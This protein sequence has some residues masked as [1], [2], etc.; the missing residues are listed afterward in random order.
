MIRLSIILISLLTACSMLAQSAEVRGRVMCGKQPVPFAQVGLMRDGSGALADSSGYFAFESHSTYDDTLLVMSIGFETLRR[1]IKLG[2]KKIDLGIVELVEIDL[3]AGEIVVSGSLHAVNRLESIV[4]VEVYSRG[5]LNKNPVC[6]VFES[7]QQMNGVRPQINCNICS[8]GDIHINGMEGPYTM[9]LIDGMPIVSSLATVYGFSG[10]PAS[11]IERVEVVK[12]PAGALYG[13]EAMGGLI[14]IIT[15]NT[16]DR[17]Q[18]ALDLMSTSWLEHNLDASANYRVGKKMSMLSSLN[19]FHFDERIDQNNDRFTD[20]PT[21]KRIS[22]FQKI[23][24]SRPSDKLFSIAGRYL[25]EDRFGGE[26]HWQRMH[27]GGRDVYG[28]S[29]YTSRSEIISQYELPVR[30]KMVFSLS[31]NDHRQN[32]VYGETSFIARQSIAFGQLTHEKMVGQHHF[33]SGLV[34]RYTYYDDNTAATAMEL[35]PESGY[36]PHQWLHGIFIQDEYTWNESH[37]T[38]GGLRLEY[39]PL[40]GEI[41]TPRFG[42]RWQLNAKQLLRLNAGKGFRVVNIFTEDHAALTGARELVIVN[43]LRPETSWNVNMN[44]H[45]QLIAHSQRRLSLDATVYYTRF[46]NRIVADYETNAN[47]IIYNNISG[48]AEGLGSSVTLEGNIGSVFSGMFGATFM[49]NRIIDNGTMRR[50]LLTERFSAV[51]SLSFSFRKIPLS[52]D[53]TGNMYSPMALP[54]AGSLDP[55]PS[56]SPWWSIQNIQLK[57]KSHKGLECYAGVKNLLDR[58]PADA[59]DFLIARAHDPFDTQVQFDAAGNPIATTEN[60]Y[61]LTFDP[62]YVFAPNQGIRVFAGLAWVFSSA[63]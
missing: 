17:P 39:H 49:D 16:T 2:A 33:I 60:P 25:Y 29:I 3:M 11:V 22:F 35:T 50:P 7:L 54:L 45:R 42:H 32:S 10:I 26:L 28:E 44:Y 1:P 9:V 61:A 41:F 15:R 27:R 56:H 51:W 20:I 30:E 13:S 34:S 14:N 31:L 19:V 5:F 8:T 38:L 40:H 62:T 18:I 23:N 47:K 53:Y 48:Y 57:W 59:A 43:S 36:Q 4:P 24:V 46:G 21:Q 37:K 55:R 58:T 63:K 12:G 6:N 52:I